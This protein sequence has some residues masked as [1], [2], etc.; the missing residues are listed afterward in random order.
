L[1][2]LHCTVTRVLYLLQAQI[3]QWSLSVDPIAIYFRAESVCLSLNNNE[4]PLI[5][6]T[7]AESESNPIAVS[8]SNWCFCLHALCKLKLF[9]MC[10]C[11]NSS[12]RSEGAMVCQTVGNRWPNSTVPH[13]S[14][15]EPSA[16]PLW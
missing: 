9:G 5:T 8:T 15:P 12:W 4:T 11:V 14:K 13:A 3:W 1:Y 2:K 7:A 6:I 10:H 16:A